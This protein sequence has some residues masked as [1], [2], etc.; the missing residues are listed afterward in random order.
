MNRRK[1]SSQRLVE[2]LN[3]P[4]ELNVGIKPGYTFRSFSP[5]YWQKS[6]GAWSWMITAAN[7]IEIGSPDT[8]ADCLKSKKLAWADPYGLSAVAP[9]TIYA[10]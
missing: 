9:G 5:G 3:D 7:G 8:V 10:E 2:R 1:K 4:E 6:A